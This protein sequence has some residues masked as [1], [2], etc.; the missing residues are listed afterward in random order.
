MK[1]LLA[2]NNQSKIAR[3]RM[4]LKDADVE[5]V[6]TSDVGLESIEVEEGS[7]IRE[8]AKNKALA[9]RG[10]TEL[11]I[12]GMDS[13]LVIPGED[14][15]PARVKRNAL[16]DRDE[17]TMTQQEIRDAMILFYQTIVKRH[18]EPVGAYW[19]DVSALVMPDG[20]VTI[21]S[22]QRP[23]VITG[24]IHGPVNDFYPL[25]SM[26]QVAAT[27]KYPIEQTPEEEWVELAPFREALERLLGLSVGS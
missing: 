17:A 24:E 5:F 4:L 3:V 10:K 23:I 16:G 13:A 12:I 8:N 1:I 11:P 15:D 7:D 2:T 18:G 25:R 20:T 19:E 27:G 22:G 9:Y 6:T 26:Y 21:E 14:L